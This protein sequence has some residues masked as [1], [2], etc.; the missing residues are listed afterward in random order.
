[1]TSKGCNNRIKGVCSVISAILINLLTGSL[2]TF[3]NLIPFYEIYTQRQFSKNQLYFV[4]PAGIFM[5]N[6]LPS[7]TGILDTK[8]GPR[9]L[10]IV[11]S[12][13]L[14]G[15]QLIIYFTKNYPLLILSYILFGFCG[16]LTYY[17]SLKNCWKYYHN[18]KGLISGIVF[19]SFGLS[20][21]IFTTIADAL[22]KSEKNKKDE[23]TI[24]AFELYL[25]IV[26]IC[27]GV[28]GT[29]SSILCFPYKKQDDYILGLSVI[30][31]EDGGEQS[32]KEERHYSVELKKDDLSER[33]K[34]TLKQ[35]ICSKDFLL[36]LIIASCT[37][38]FGFLLNNTY[39]TFGHTVFI[40]H[41][42]EGKGASDDDLK[43]NEEHLKT[44]SKV[45][46]LL[47][48]FSRLIWGF[49][50]DH[51]RFKILYLIVC[52]NQIL[53]GA[54]IYLSTNTMLTYF[55][56]V[57]FGVLSYSGHIVLFPNLIHIK[58]GVE[59]SV[60]LLGIC[61]IFSGIAALIG[62]ILTIFFLK[63]PKDYLI[64]YIAG[65]APTIAS[66]FIAIFIKVEE[67]KKKEVT[68]IDNINSNDEVENLDN[69]NLNE[70]GVELNANKNK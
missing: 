40:A 16:S 5:H 19:S 66:F 8:F 36:C 11:G 26:L 33:E 25:K 62:P 67:K 65:V 12:I 18:H 70:D 3:P 7:V 44:L 32:P 48:T 27:F 37:L 9:I 1:M 29:L 4:A 14:L 50:S 51:V 42:K 34:R 30:T 49:I 20:A 57:N 15:S 58:F 54:L 45:F 38:T 47:N 28:V 39:R 2:F 68:N 6:A 64:I 35:T 63:E 60:N 69:E 17:Q 23:K 59:K 10:N 55:I 61:G 41:G 31:N 52:V 56:V 22:N 43:K 13:C 24:K 46:T 21:F 53:C